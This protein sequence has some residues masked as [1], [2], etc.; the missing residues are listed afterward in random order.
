MRASVVSCDQV[1]DISVGADSA[2]SRARSRV[3]AVLSTLRDAA[4]ADYRL[5]V[6]A[7]ATADPDPEAHRILI[8]RVFPRQAEVIDADDLSALSGRE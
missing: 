5:Y 7:D 3:I 6:L 1:D 4:D 2:R 8:E